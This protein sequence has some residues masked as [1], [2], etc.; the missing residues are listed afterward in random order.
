ML[1]Q[2]GVGLTVSRIIRIIRLASIVRV[3]RCTIR[4]ARLVRVNLREELVD[5][6]VNVDQLKTQIAAGYSIINFKEQQSSKDWRGG[7][8]CC[9]HRICRHL[10]NNM[11]VVIIVIITIMMILIQIVT[12]IITEMLIIV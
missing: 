9:M 1:W 10:R 7:M 4:L 2:L 12:I 8:N 5:V 6:A 3:V 11:I